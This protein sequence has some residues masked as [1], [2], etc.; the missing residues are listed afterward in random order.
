MGKRILLADDHEFVRKGLRTVIQDRDDWEI[1]G[2]AENGREAVAMAAELEPDIVV[3]DISMPELNGLDAARQILSE[4]PDTG[5]LIDEV[6]EGT[7]ADHAGLQGGDVILQWGDTEITG[8]RALFESLQKHEPGD[9]VQLK[10]Q[11][12]DDELTVPVKLQA[13]DG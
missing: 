7:S 3:L 6:S 8:M 10:I 2:E 4:H 11:R 5:V 9:V 12:G 13:S 1:C